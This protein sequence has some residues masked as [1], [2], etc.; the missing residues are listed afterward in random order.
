MIKEKIGFIGAGIMGE[1]LIRGIIEKKVVDK[2]NI[3]ASDIDKK[4]LN[5]LKKE[6]K[7]NV[8]NSNKDLVKLTDIVVL[9]VKPQ[10]IS[11]V[12][13]EIKDTLTNDVLLISIAAGISLK[14][15]ENKFSKKIPIVRVM[16]NTPC[17]IGEGISGISYN[18]NCKLAHKRIA[19]KFFS[20]VG[21]IAVVEEKHLNAITAIS[22]SGPAY[23]FLMI[24]ALSDAGV[25][26]GLTRDLSQTLS[27]QTTLGAAKLALSTG[28]HPAE[29]K[30]MVSSPGGTT[31]AALHTLEKEGFRASLINAVY[32]AYQRAKELS[33]G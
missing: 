20:S 16:P 8:A 6:L 5:F 4:R 14:F 13:D 17:L 25:R 33:K 27:V 11:S 19:E 21:K 30:D 1:A 24:E 23:V 28:K 9:S 7:I 3:F 26:I 15:L 10:V 12:I 22:G 31:I 29:L 32:S 2:K 18:K